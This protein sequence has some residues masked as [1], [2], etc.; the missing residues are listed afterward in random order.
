MTTQ[1]LFLAR[2]SGLWLASSQASALWVWIRPNGWQGNFSA[3]WPRWGDLPIAP[4]PPCTWYVPPTHTYCG[5]LLVCCGIQML[6]G[7]WYR[8][9][10]YKWDFLWLLLLLF[11]LCSLIENSICISF[12]VVNNRAVIL[13]LHFH[14]SPE[15]LQDIWLPKSN[16]WKVPDTIIL[17]R[18]FNPL[19]LL[20]DLLDLFPNIEM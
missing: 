4:T 9:I 2:R 7:R 6:W 17:D 8:I 13:R 1:I 20:S 14:T 3:P 18:K 15:S 16:L 12:Q 10:Q 5:L 11:S 19:A